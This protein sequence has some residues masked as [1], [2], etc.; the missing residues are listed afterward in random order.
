MRIGPMGGRRTVAGGFG[1]AAANS[2]SRVPM[3]G[4]GA[5]SSAL[6]TASATSPP[7]PRHASTAALTLRRYST[8]TSSARRIVALVAATVRSHQ[9]STS[10]CFA[11]SCAGL[12]S[13][14]FMAA[15]ASLQ[16][17]TYSHGGSWP[18][19]PTKWPKV[20]NTRPLGPVT[21]GIAPDLLA[22]YRR[23]QSWLTCPRALGTNLDLRYM[24]II[25]ARGRFLL[26]ATSFVGKAFSS[27]VSISVRSLRT[28]PAHAHVS[29]RLLA[30][31]WLARGMNP[32][33]PL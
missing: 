8:S 33:G 32:S 1:G 13:S 27:T 12:R 15:G 3:V 11:S 21:T 2:S 7:L 29:E 22:S 23:K 28:A 25:L 30:T 16:R 9:S 5:Y 6:A 14:G 19:H 26:R 18:S 4:R 10:C 24:G 20:S 17:S 31:V